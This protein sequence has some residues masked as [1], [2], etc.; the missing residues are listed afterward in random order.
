MRLR[1]LMEEVVNL[2]LEDVWKDEKMCKCEK[3][4][5]DILAQSLNNLPTRYL[6][7]DRGHAFSKTEFLELQK[8]IDVIKEL[9]VAVRMVKNNPR[10]N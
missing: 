2:S 10:H 7:T 3:C 5:L 1:N 6:V 8:N 9:A 4:R